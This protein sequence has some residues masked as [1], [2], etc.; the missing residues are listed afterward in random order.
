MQTPAEFYSNLDQQL[1]IPAR[2]PSPEIQYPYPL[3]K[4]DGDFKRSPMKPNQASESNFSPIPII[5][6]FKHSEYF[7]GKFHVLH[8]KTGAIRKLSLPWE[9]GIRCSIKATKSLYNDLVVNGPFEFLMTAK[10]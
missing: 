2:S 9:H 5:I 6:F 10:R 8:T 7:L 1:L 4:Q 3:F